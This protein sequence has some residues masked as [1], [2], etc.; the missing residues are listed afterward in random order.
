[1]EETKEDVFILGL[2][3]QLSHGL[4][5]SFVTHLYLLEPIDD[6]ALLEQV[7]SRA[8]RLGATGPVCIETVHI[9]N[10]LDPN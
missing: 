2:D 10:Q 5:L 9:W 8:H 7:T 6:A 3:A 1:M 4:D